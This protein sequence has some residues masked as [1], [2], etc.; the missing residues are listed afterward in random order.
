MEIV[1]RATVNTR[2]LAVMP[3]SFNPPTRAHIGLAEAAL[4]HADEVLFAIP[5]T[6]PHKEYHG[7]TLDQRV[8]MLGAAAP[9][10]S[11]TIA[12][13]DQGLFIDIARELRPHY[14][15]SELVFLCGRDAAERVVSWSYSEGSIDEMLREFG[16][17]VASRDGDYDPPDH[18]G[19]AI[20]ALICANY[21]EVSS[22]A[23]RDRIAAGL[24]WED[25]VPQPIVEAV[26]EIYSDASRNR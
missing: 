16:L 12:V 21:D 22:S 6:F 3:G 25:L 10:D 2:R 24:P 9:W 26:R 13:A 19:H 4:R 23:V 7:A 17:L 14:P 5:R 20:T 8:A 1:R 11:A 18:L 15:E